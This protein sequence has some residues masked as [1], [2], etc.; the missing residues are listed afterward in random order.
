MAKPNPLE[1]IRQEYQQK[2]DQQLDWVHRSL[3][4]PSDVQ[5]KVEGK[6]VLMLC[7]NNYLNLSNHP[8]LKEAAID[9]VKTHGAGSGSVRAIAGN[10]DL[11][12][13]WE[14]TRPPTKSFN[15]WINLRKSDVVSLYWSEW[16]PMSPLKLARGSVWES[17]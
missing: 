10:M 4:G 16:G 3:E 13:K 6:E 8:K 9:A 14:K 15:I 11:H 1:F 7:S 5:C 17:L 12:E 2:V